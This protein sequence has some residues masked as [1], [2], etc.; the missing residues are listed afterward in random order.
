MTL[1]DAEVMHFK[2]PLKV[3]IWIPT[4]VTRDNQRVIFSKL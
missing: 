1:D 2:S 3:G 4:V